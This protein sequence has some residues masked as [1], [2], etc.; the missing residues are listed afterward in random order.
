MFV[1]RL[2]GPFPEGLAGF[3]PRSAFPPCG[4]PGFANH[5]FHLQHGIHG[6]AAA[7]PHDAL[8]AQRRMQRSRRHRAGMGRDEAPRSTVRRVG[9]SGFKVPVF[10]CHPETTRKAV[11]YQEKAMRKGNKNISKHSIILNTTY[12]FGLDDQDFML[13]FETDNLR[14][15]QDLI[16]ELRETKV[17]KYVKVDTPMIICVKKE[18]KELIASLG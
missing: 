7:R 5:L 13:A 10:C 14:D 9:D 17:S 1:D 12:S 15:F 8:P 2:P 3:G 11:L 16:M 6:N 18:I 4:F